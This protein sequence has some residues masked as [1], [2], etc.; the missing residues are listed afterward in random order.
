MFR[1]PLNPVATTATTAEQQR[2]VAPPVLP[3][4]GEIDTDGGGETSSSVPTGLAQLM[5]EYNLG[6][7]I[8]VQKPDG[9]YTLY[10]PDG[11]PLGRF[12]PDGEGN[13]LWIPGGGT[14]TNCFLCRFCPSPLGLCIFVWAL[15]AIMVTVIIMHIAKK[16][17][18]D[19][20]DDEELIDLNAV[21]SYQDE[22]FASIEP[23]GAF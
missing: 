17:K 22:Q 11:T 5:D 2:P 9:S 18:G 23:E 13:W 1:P 15:I 6:G 20:E 4:S 21:Y 12:V 3:P 19:K 16:R 8:L 14:I 7:G 10:S